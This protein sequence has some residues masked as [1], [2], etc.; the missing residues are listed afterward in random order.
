MTAQKTPALKE[1]ATRAT[2]AIIQ[3]LGDKAGD[4]RQLL[5]NLDLDPIK[6]EIIKAEYG[7]GAAQKDVTEASCKQA[8]S[9]LCR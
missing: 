6:V 9:R 8:G 7:A 1:N 4:A 2:L 5:A 3:K